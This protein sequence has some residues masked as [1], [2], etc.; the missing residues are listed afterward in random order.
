MHSVRA[1]PML[2]HVT[3]SSLGYVSTP[4]DSF[5]ESAFSVTYRQ[6]PEISFFSYPPVVSRDQLFQ[7]PTGDFPKSAF[8]VTY[9]QLPE[10]SIFSS[11]PVITRNQPFQFLTSNYLNIGG[12]KTSHPLRSISF[13][14]A[15]YICN[16]TTT[17]FASGST[18]SITVGDLSSCS[19]PRVVQACGNAVVPFTPGICFVN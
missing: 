9:R 8:S 4:T 2:A 12:R 19:Y 11:L 10:I 15:T 3:S 13:S 16:F 7:L 1:R 6:L 17:Q 5:P 18:T 14:D